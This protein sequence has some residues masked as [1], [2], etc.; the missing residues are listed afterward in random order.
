MRLAVIRI[1]QDDVE[2]YLDNLRTRRQVSD[3]ALE[4]AIAVWCA[5]GEAAIGVQSDTP[6]SRELG[7]LTHPEARTVGTVRSLVVTE[8]AD[9][10]KADDCSTRARIQSLTVVTEKRHSW[11]WVALL[12]HSGPPPGFARTLPHEVNVGVCST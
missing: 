2:C 7:E 10:A 6:S 5:H 12:T 4:H 1:R 8:A 11:L 9:E 3:V